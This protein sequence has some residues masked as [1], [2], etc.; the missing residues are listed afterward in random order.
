MDPQGSLFPFLE[1]ITP[2]LKMLFAQAFVCIKEPLY[3]THA[4]AVK[5]LEQDDFFRLAAHPTP[6]PVGEDFLRLYAWAAAASPP[7]ALLHLCFLDRV[8]FALQSGYREQFMADIRAVQTEQAPLI[9]QRSEAAWESHPHN[10]RE[11][12]QMVTRVGEL[13]FNRS[14][15][16][17]W[18]HL[19]V[20]AGQLQALAPYIKKRDLSMLAEFVLLLRDE[21]RTQAVDWLAW[22]KPFTEGRE[23]Q[24]FKQ[25]QEHS[26]AE[27]Q[28]RLNYVIPMLQLLREAAK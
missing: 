1:A 28:K 17:A 4:A 24:Q 9:F 20:Q 25:Q 19:V 12:E 2:D 22:E 16:F 6:F 8:T 11:L 26:L 13:L 7:Q 15:D 5:Q 23:P 21:L 10:Y 18:C 27:T 14:L 3:E